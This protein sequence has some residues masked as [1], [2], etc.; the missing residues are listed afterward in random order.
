[1]KKAPKIQDF[2][3]KNQNTPEKKSPNGLFKRFLSIFP[4]H[5]A[6]K[7]FK[8]TILYHFAQ[9]FLCPRKKQVGAPTVPSAFI[10]NSGE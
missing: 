10:A 2:F 4:P 9:T 8:Y 3:F 5:K 6:K 7:G 1:V